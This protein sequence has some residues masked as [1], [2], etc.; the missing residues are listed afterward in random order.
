VVE[1]PAFVQFVPSELVEMTAVPGDARPTATQVPPP[2]ARPLIVPG[3]LA[4]LV[5]VQLMLSVDLRRYD[6]VAE[7]AIHVVPSQAIETAPPAVAALAVRVQLIP[8]GEVIT[9]VFAAPAHRLPFHARARIGAEP[10][11]FV[12]DARDHVVVGSAAY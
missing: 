11:K 12:G 1:T 2:Q 5:F 8:S 9:P 3:I 7:P 6:A 10:D 4:G